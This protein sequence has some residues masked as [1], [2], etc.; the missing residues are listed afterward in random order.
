MF[1]DEERLIQETAARYAR[2]SL[3]PRAAAWDRGESTPEAAIAEMGALGFMGLVIPERYGG[4]GGSYVSFMLAMEEIAAGDGGLSTFL[5]VHSLGGASPIIRFGTEE[6]KI[7]Y[8]PKMATGE[9][10]GAFCLTEPHTGSDAA[11]IKTRA[12]RVSGG[13]RLTTW[14]RTRC[15]PR[16]I[17]AS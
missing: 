13:W 10:V 17:D 6:Q 15:W 9:C 1:S 2:T 7:R 4:G 8:L 14:R 3:A 12:R 11:A 5:H 16:S